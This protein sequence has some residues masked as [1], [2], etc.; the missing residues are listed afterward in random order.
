M[1]DRRGRGRRDNGLDAALWF[2]LRDVDPRVGEHLLDVLE[3]VGIAAYLEPSADVDSYT[4][5]VSLPSPPSDRL[6]VDRSRREEA[7]GLVDQHADEHPDPPR[8]VARTPRPEVDEDAEWQRIVTAFEA[9]HGRTVVDESPSTAPP[10]VP[11]EVPVLDRPDEHYE[12]PAP[13][14]LPVP[15][16]AA[17]YAVLLVAAGVLLI[18]AP[19]VLGLSADVGLVLGVAVVAGGVAMLVA[20]MR[21][22]AEDGDDGAVV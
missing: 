15:A 22:R 3:T 17:L 13:P 18:G 11:H 7:R 10:P 14:P 2:P 21:D 4:R 6:F 19:A 9:E 8:P 1:T 16:P 5:S 20:R 12:P